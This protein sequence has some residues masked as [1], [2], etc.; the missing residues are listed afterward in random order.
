MP[1]RALARLC[2]VSL[3]TLYYHVHKQGWRRRRSDVPRDLAKSERQR[4]RYRE[5]KALRPAAPRGLKARDPDGQA[6]AL[7]ALERAAALSGAALSRALA[8]QETE[9]KARMLSLLTQALRDLAIANGDR[10]KR[11]RGKTRGEAQEK[12]RRRRPY[13]WRPM[14]RRRPG[15]N[16]G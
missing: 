10:P 7:A 6:Q 14:A 4:R 2:G 5:L 9:A 15:R 8:R 1:V 3:R 12:P 13:Q 16:G 11:S